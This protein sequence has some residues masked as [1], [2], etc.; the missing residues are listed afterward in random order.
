VWPEARNAADRGYEIGWTIAP[1]LWGQGLAREA[2][3]AVLAWAWRNTACPSIVAITRPATRA[4][5][6]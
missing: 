6:L 5:G 2:A 1:D 3:E 4:A